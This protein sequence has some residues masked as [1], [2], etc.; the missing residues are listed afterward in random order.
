VGTDEAQ[1]AIAA[2][3]L[4]EIGGG[5]VVVSE[6]KVLGEI[7]LPIGGLMSTQSARKVAAE[8]AELLYGFRECG[9]N[10]NSPNMT[11]SLLGLVVIPQLRI[12]DLGLVDVD[13]FDFI[14]VIEP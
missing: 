7:R 2:N 6:G 4:A 9:C 8:A 12:S 3:H 1:M 11:L 10:L 13:R 5:Q 14:P